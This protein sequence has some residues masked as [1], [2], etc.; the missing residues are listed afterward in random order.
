MKR[1]NKGQRNGSQARR[2]PETGRMLRYLYEAKDR[3]GYQHTGDVKGRS[4]KEAKKR[5]QAT[6]PFRAVSIRLVPV[7]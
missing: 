3:E 5:C 7:G 1:K 6:L 2:K 4:F